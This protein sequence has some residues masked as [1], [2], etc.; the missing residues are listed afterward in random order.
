MVVCEGEGEME[1]R[2]GVSEAPCGSLSNSRVSA[3]VN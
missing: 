3:F 2:P 1:E